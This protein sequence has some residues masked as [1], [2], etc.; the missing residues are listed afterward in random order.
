MGKRTLNEYDVLKAMAIILVVIG[1]A[2]I[3][4]SPTKHPEQ[5]VRVAQL[6]TKA[7]YMF[8][9]PLFMAL[10]GAVYALGRARGKYAEFK[11]FALNK[12][13]RLIVPYICAGFFVLLPVICWISSGDISGHFTDMVLGR[14]C[15]H[16]W[17][18]LALAEIFVIQWV[19]DRAHVPHWLLFV[20]SVTLATTLSVTGMQCD[21]FCLNMAVWYWPYF[22]MG[23]ILTRPVG[24]HALWICPLGLAANLLASYLVHNLLIDTL[25]TLILPCWAV[26]WLVELTRLTMRR[27]NLGA[28]RPVAVLAEY[29]MAI[30]LL[31]VPVIFILHHTLKS[32]AWYLIVPVMIAAGIAV[33]IYGAKILRKIHC[34]FA[35]GE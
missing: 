19:A 34:G 7:I 6:I 35:I 25:L 22:I 26:V 1:H 9:M 24:R 11:P 5:D 29:G 15:R 27:R 12:S 13:R 16:L 21:I 4:Y 14:D 32:A 17:Y 31:H 20:F 33:G 28:W 10:S 18:L 3:L 30:Y 2:T 8:H 23:M